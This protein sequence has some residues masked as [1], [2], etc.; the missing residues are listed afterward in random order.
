MNEDTLPEPSKNTKNQQILGRE[1]TGHT[2]A[3]T[4]AVSSQTAAQPLSEKSTTA[5]IQ[6]AEV[7]VTKAE[8]QVTKAE[9]EIQD[10]KVQV[11]KAEAE[12]KDA[13][14]EVKDAKA[15]VKDAKA[16]VDEAEAKLAQ[17]PANEIWK[18]NLKERHEA[19]KYANEA[20]KYAN[21][22][23]K[24]ANEALK[25]AF[26]TLKRREEFYFSLRKHSIGSSVEVSTEERLAKRAKTDSTSEGRMVPPLIA[27]QDVVHA[28][29]WQLA[30]PK[31]HKCPNPNFTTL[32]LKSS[33]S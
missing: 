22:A 2:P 7:Q 31:D 28:S 17:D 30:N 32:F 13:K 25:S 19:L 5:E 1:I 23:L 4:A 27:L 3:D 8:A 11:T 29:L 10:A 15:E 6:D 12:V 14:A 9:A 21:E 18:S 33:R 20:L 24:Y 26:E 16:K